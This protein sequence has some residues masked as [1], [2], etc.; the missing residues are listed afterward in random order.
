[1]MIAEPTWIVGSIDP[2]PTMIERAPISGAPLPRISPPRTTAIRAT[3]P[4]ST[5]RR[6]TTVALARIRIR[7]SSR[8]RAA[9]RPLGRAAVGGAAGCFGLRV[10]GGL[11]GAE[12]ERCRGARTLEGVRGREREVHPEAE[13]LVRTG[14]DRAVTGVRALGRAAHRGAVE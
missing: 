10:V 4:R 9:A 11:F 12:R 6:S 5:I 7:R 13:N 3:R 2:P 14:C 1:M 8:N